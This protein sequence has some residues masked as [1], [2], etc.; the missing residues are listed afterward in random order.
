MMLWIISSC[1]FTNS[2]DVYEME[3]DYRI[4]GG[5]EISDKMESVRETN[6]QDI[7]KQYQ[8][9]SE[10]GGIDEKWNIAGLHLPS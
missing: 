10:I 8:E 3:S 6:W 4:R 2:S 9:R 5:P 7:W 1:L